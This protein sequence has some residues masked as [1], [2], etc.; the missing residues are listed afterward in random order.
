[1]STPEGKPIHCRGCRKITGYLS[2]GSKLAKG[3]EHICPKC[4]D[5]INTKLAADNLRDAANGINGGTG[6][7]FSDIFG[8]LFKG[9]RG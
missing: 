8:D 2:D 7:I 4:V 1:M 3:T 6:D 5:K 9:K